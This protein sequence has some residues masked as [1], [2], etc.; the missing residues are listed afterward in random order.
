M[1][2]SL[3]SSLSFSEAEFWENICIIVAIVSGVV[4]VFGLIGEYPDSEAWKKRRL[5]TLSKWGV[6][7]GVVGEL[8]GD[9]GIFPTSGQ[10]QQL[11]DS[12]IKESFGV[13]KAIVDQVKPRGFSG[14]QFEK[15]AAGL[16]GKI[17]H[18]DVV[19]LPDS[20]AFSFALAIMRIL[21]QANIDVTWYRSKTNRIEIEGVES[22]G[23]VLYMPGVRD[24]PELNEFVSSFFGA[25]C[26]NAPPTCTSLTP[27]NPLPNVPG[28]TLFVM[29]HP[30]PL[31]W[32]R[33]ES[34]LP[35]SKIPP[36]PWEPR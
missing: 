6:I 16:R 35:G 25:F 27:E 5:Y 19:T 9:A 33:E 14:D 18:L 31:S 23:V 13:E 32:Y 15:I 24:H 34:I 4:L 21:E 10:L 7:L 28:P 12:S 36:P 8:L 11:T 30:V 1:I 2:G 26:E 3:A 20:E 29:L 17:A 22:T